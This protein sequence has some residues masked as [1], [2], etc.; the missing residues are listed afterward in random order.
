MNLSQ[1]IKNLYRLQDQIIGNRLF[2][3]NAVF[4]ASFSRVIYSKTES[5]REVEGNAANWNIFWPR[6]KARK[7]CISFSL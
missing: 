7:Q 1:N 3:L 6:N 2:C 5:R 4:R